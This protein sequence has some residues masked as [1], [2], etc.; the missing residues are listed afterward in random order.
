MTIVDLHSDTMKAK[1]AYVIF[2]IWFLTGLNV[3][4]AL[5]APVLRC[6]ALDEN[7]DVTLTWSI[8]SDPNLEFFKYVIYYKPTSGPFSQLAEI[9][10]YYTDSKLING[11]F[12]G[13]VQFYM[14]TLSNGGADVSVPSDT[15]SPM[16]VSLFSADREVDISWSALDL[17]SVDSVYKVYRREAPSGPWQFIGSTKHPVI[18]MK[19]TID[20]CSQEVNYKVEVDGIGGCI[21]RS[22]VPTRLVEDKRPPLQ[23]NLICASVDPATGFVALEWDRSVSDD[24]Y[25]YLVIYFEDFVRIDTVFGPDSLNAVFDKNGINA[26]LQPELLSVA[27]FDS[28][29]DSTVLW[30][31]QAADSLRFYTLFVD[32]IMFDRCAGKVGLQWNMPTPEN[33][34]GVRDLTSFRVYRQTND[35]PAELRVVLGAGDSVFTDSGLVEGNS[36]TYRIAAFDSARNKEAF[37]NPKDMVIAPANIPQ[38]N[39]ISGIVNDHGSGLNQVH[40]VTDT[41]SETVSYGLFRSL[42]E[43]ENFQLV[44]SSS[45]N[46]NWQ[47]SI[48]DPTGQAS[49]TDYYYMIASYDICEDIIWWSDPAKSMYVDGF[50]IE[51]DYLNSLEWTPYEGYDHAGTVVDDYVLYRQTNTSEIEEVYADRVQLQYDDDIFPLEHV[52]GNVCYYVEAL[53]GGLSPYGQVQHSVSNLFCLNYGPRVFIPNAFSP[54]GDGINDRFLPNVNFIDPQGYQLMVY[55][56]SGSL[57]FSSS[58]PAEGWDGGDLGIGV[59]AFHLQLTNALGE[60]VNYTGKVHLIR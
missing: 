55:D 6:I 20:R 16:L 30:Y 53:D 47:I 35:E 3:L 58:N 5:D 40:I 10:T 26:L 13:Q 18:T 46:N 27:P 17:Q 32:T 49:Q 54:D 29:F 48:E 21:N 50:K 57:V 31:N 4:A 39:F 14:V 52:D 44:A 8:P 41:N 34:V 12:S 36:Y 1:A 60:G 11:S 24:A 15:V 19:D 28:C 42:H 56:R 25:G 37:S 45:K 33:P 23:T 22:N 51:R 38:Y 2:S 43:T 9:N 59:Y 7:D